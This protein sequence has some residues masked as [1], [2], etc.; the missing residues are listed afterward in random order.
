MVELRTTRYKKVDQLTGLTIVVPPSV[1]YRITNATN[2]T[3]TR[4]IDTVW[5]AMNRDLDVR[6]T[7]RL[8]AFSP[9]AP[10]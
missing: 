7:H 1:T 5:V 3:S 10:M 4:T 2:Q 8:T 9:A 6:N